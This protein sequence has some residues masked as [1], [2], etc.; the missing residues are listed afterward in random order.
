MSRLRKCFFASVSLLCGVATCNGVAKSA[1]G[2]VC[3]LLSAPEA[4]V[5]CNVLV[6][7]EVGGAF[8]I[9]WMG[10][11]LLQVVGVPCFVIGS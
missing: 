4:I 2:G 6:L 9:G 7:V 11:R 1:L 8:G 10:A 3:Y 5:L